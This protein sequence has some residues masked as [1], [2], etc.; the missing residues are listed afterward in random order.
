MII[1]ASRRNDIPAFYTEWF[2]NRIADGYVLVRNPINMHHVSRILLTPEVVDCI[3]FWTKNPAP[4][5]PRLCQLSPYNFYFQFT[6]T[7][8]NRDLE[9]HLPSKKEL[10]N[11]FSR[12]SE[13]LGRERV[14]WRYDPIVLTSKYSVQFHLNA[15]A[16]MSNILGKYT[17]RCVISF[18]D[19]YQKS[20]RNLSKIEVEELSVKQMREVAVFMSNIA[21]YSGIELVSCAEELDLQNLGIS[22]GKCIDDKLVAEISGYELN[23]GK[24]KTQRPECGCVA[25]IDIGSYNTCSHGCLY[26]YANADAKAVKKNFSEHDVKS[27]LLFGHISDNDHITARKVLSCRVLQQKLAIWDKK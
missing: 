8:Y 3:V 21:R 7:P 18:I 5:I 27:P 12:L 10:M 4:I 13:I 22:H 20:R 25:S 2:F 15:F 11:T 23:I 17:R 6:I 14:I 9:P 16:E 19:M 1:S 24:D 26:C